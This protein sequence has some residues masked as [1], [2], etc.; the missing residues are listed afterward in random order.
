MKILNLCLCVSVLSISVFAP[1][2]AQQAPIAK[3]N[4][5]QSSLTQGAT[6]HTKESAQQ[7]GLI[8]EMPNG[9]VGSVKGAYKDAYIEE[10][11][12]HINKGRM[13]V[14]KA[15]ARKKNLPIQYVQA[16]AADTLYKSVGP[17]HYYYK[18]GKWQRR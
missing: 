6:K 1:A 14:Y 3:T 5:P 16:K 2:L 10:L 9:L 13:I 11:I 17:G 4:V 18:N 15:A 12:K 7:Y 8:G